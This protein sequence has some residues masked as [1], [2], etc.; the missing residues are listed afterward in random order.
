MTVSIGVADKPTE[1]D[2]RKTTAAAFAFM[3]FALA[4]TTHTA[5]HDEP[6]PSLE[7]AAPIGARSLERGARGRDVAALQLALAWH[8]F[9]SGPLDGRF[10]TRT[11]SALRLFQRWAQLT[12]DGK[13]GAATFAALRKPPPRAPISLSAPSTGLLGD[14][15]GQR[16]R[17]FHAGLDFLAPAGDQVA[18][19]AGGRVVFA[20]AHGGGWGKL[21]VLAHGSGVRT[22]YA[23][24]SRIDVRPGAHVAAGSTIG[25][26]GATG[27]ATGPH[28]HFEVHVRGAAVDPATALR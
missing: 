18:A 15:F 20:R 24:L 5:A 10:G 16:G 2:M 14:G 7:R 3:A 6:G 23:H 27:R 28:L 9:P 13:A 11:E 21:V 1:G 22:L 8:G 26:V 19:A 17:N 25:L 12:P 4:F